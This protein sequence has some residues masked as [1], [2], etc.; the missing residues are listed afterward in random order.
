MMLAVAL[1]YALERKRMTEETSV[2]PMRRW[3]LS[4]LILLHAAGRL[5]GYYVFYGIYNSPLCYT[6]VCCIE[7][8]LIET[9]SFIYNRIR[10]KK[11]KFVLSEWPYFPFYP[12][13]PSHGNYPLSF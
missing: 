5:S 3:L 12:E 7:I 10:K 1:P 8:V 11:R 2:M 4:S 9:M 13:Q 6:D